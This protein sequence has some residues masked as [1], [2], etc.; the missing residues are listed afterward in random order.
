MQNTG[1]YKTL[2][3]PS[4]QNTMTAINFFL[5]AVKIRYNATSEDY[6]DYLKIVIPEKQFGSGIENE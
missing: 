2:E 4:L 3:F 1:V 5:L 6:I